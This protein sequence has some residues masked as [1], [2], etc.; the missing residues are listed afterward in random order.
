MTNSIQ[1]EKIDLI[2]IIASTDDSDLLHR[3]REVVE[4]TAHGLSGLVEEP[5]MQIDLEQLK[6]E[7]GYLTE[8]VATL[9]GQWFIDDDYFELLQM[10]D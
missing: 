1:T 5:A 6:S 2:K 3:I 9:H 7:Q 8:H 4:D 10:L